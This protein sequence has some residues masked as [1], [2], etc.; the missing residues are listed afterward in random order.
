MTVPWQIAQELHACT[1]T[2]PAPKA[3]DRAHDLL[4]LQLL[5]VLLADANLAQTRLACVAVFEARAEQVWPPAVRALPHWPVIYDRA[6][7]GLDHPHLAESACAARCQAIRRRI[8]HELRSVSVRRQPYPN[9]VINC[10]C[11]R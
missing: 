11:N 8:D 4:D 10:G 1:A 9:T 6:R 3:N 7:E 2:L 5:E